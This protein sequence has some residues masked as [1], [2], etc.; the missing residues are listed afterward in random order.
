ML[1]ASSPSGFLHP[2]L[3]SSLF[4]PSHTQPIEHTEWMSKWMKWISDCAHSAFFSLRRPFLTITRERKWTWL[5]TRIMTP[6]QVAITCAFPLMQKRT[7]CQRMSLEPFYVFFLLLLKSD[8][9][10][11]SN[12]AASWNLQYLIHPLVETH[13]EH[14]QFGLLWQVCKLTV[15]FRVVASFK[16]HIPKPCQLVDRGS[17]AGV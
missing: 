4:P 2:S 12:S 1:D 7:P 11:V 6:A 9:F 14:F 3:P 15:A 8:V 10:N 5:H 13:S 17:L 16:T